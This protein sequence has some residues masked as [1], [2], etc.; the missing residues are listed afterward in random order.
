[1]E[2]TLR[3][4]VVTFQTGR[5]LLPHSAVVEVLPY[6]KPL[7]IEN[8]PN[9]VVG[10]ILWKSIPIPLVSLERLIYRTSPGIGAHSRIIIVHALGDDPKLRDFGLLGTEPP[11][12]D[13]LERGA[14]EDDPEFKP[15]T[16]GVL[17]WVRFYGREALIPDMDAIEEELRKA[18]RS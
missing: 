16:T 11:Q 2:Q 8:A 18:L 7:R 13:D 1:M 12:L 10:S 17:R 5:A 4:M 6:A 9:W 14:I 3:I 15:P